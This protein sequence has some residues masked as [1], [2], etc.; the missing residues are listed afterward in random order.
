MQPPPTPS[1][2]SAGNRRTQT[3]SSGPRDKD[4]RVDNLVKNGIFIIPDPEVLPADLEIHVTE[5]RDKSRDSPGLSPEELAQY[6]SE[7]RAV[8]SGYGET[9][10]TQL[11]K[12]W[13]LPSARHPPY[14][15]SGLQCHEGISM[16]PHLIPAHPAASATERISVPKPDFLYGYA[17]SSV[18]LPGNVCPAPSFDAV[19]A[20]PFSQPQLLAQEKLDKYPGQKFARANSERL[21]FPFFVVELKADAGTGGSIWVAGNQGAGGSAACLNAAER[22]NDLLQETNQPMIDNLTYCVA[23]D[24]RSAQLYV[25]W[26]PDRLT[27]YMYEVRSYVLSRNEEFKDF[28][29]HVRNILDWGKDRRLQQIRDALDAI[30]EEDCKRTAEGAKNRST[31]SVVGSSSDGPAPK[32]RRSSGSLGRGQ[33]G[34][35]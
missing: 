25:S 7:R 27:Y 30:L 14:R 18:P 19:A 13:V 9:T 21:L 15:G 33:G 5:I 17:G 23:M 20:S 16:S 26:K 32:R 22:L 28:R 12:D 10:V 35:G 1:T 34:S 4:Y 8:E 24:Q 29:R 3:S 11:V 2:N 31:P 6:R